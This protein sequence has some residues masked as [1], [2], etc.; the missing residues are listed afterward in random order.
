MTQEIEKYESFSPAEFPI[1]ETLQFEQ[2]GNSQS[3]AITL[4]TVLRSTDEADE[5]RLR[6]SFTK[7]TDFRFEPGA[8]PVRLWPLIISRV[9]PQWQDIKFRISHSE[10]DVEFAFYCRDFKAELI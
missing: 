5:R 4:Q 3:Y 9:D 8:V 6:L 10:Q 2:G 1:L 7:V